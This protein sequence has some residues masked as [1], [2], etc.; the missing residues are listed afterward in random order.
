MTESEFSVM[1]E[2]PLI[3]MTLGGLA[4][5]YNVKIEHIHNPILHPSTRMAPD[6]KRVIDEGLIIKVSGSWDKVA[7][8]VN[9]SS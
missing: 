9:D 6:P 8:V 2:S 3:G 1:P 5:Q 4:K 7:R